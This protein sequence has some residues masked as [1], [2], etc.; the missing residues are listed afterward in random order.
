[1]AINAVMRLA[2]FDTE[3]HSVLAR[4]KHLPTY[5]KHPIVCPVKCIR[6]CNIDMNFI[7]SQYSLFF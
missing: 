7:F 1:M 6:N 3:A 5:V 2:L 4:L